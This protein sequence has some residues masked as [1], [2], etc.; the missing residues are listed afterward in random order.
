MNIYWHQILL[1]VRNCRLL[2]ASFVRSP[3]KYNSQ[4]RLD[5]RNT[6]SVKSKNSI[7][8]RKRGEKGE[9]GWVVLACKS[10]EEERQAARAISFPYSL[11]TDRRCFCSCDSVGIRSVH[12]FELA[13]K[14][15][16]DS[17]WSIYAIFADFA[18]VGLR[19][20]KSFLR[21]FFVNLYVIKFSAA[22]SV[23]YM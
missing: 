22:P 14:I 10:D 5:I 23:L 21:T 2:R 17:A 16:D 20:E 8:R 1:K 4:F 6:E 11:L 7:S 3:E 19:Y 9:V 15:W 13:D 12:T 18:H